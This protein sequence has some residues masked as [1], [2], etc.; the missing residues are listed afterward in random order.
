MNNDVDGLKVSLSRLLRKLGGNTSNGKTRRIIAKQRV[1]SDAVLRG[2]RICGGGQSSRVDGIQWAISTVIGSIFARNDA[3]FAG[4][5]CF[6]VG[7]GVR[8]GGRC[9]AAG[10]CI[11]DADG[12]R[13]V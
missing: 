11:R 4:V 10:S 6:V 8:V 1:A 13:I 7:S 12:R 9:F 3:D 2:L 5:G